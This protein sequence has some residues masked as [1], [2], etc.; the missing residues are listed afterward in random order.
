MNRRLAYVMSV[1]VV[2]LG[3]K[4]TGYAQT[5]D[6][7]LQLASREPAFYAIIGSHL[8]RAEARNVAALREHIGLHL[9][10]VTIPEALKV[11][12]TQT[13]LRFVFK[14]SILPPG[15]TVSLDANDITVAAALTQVLLDADVDVEIAPYGLTSIVARQPRNTAPDT[16]TGG[17]VG[18][19][20]DAK[21]HAGISY[22]TV[23]LDGAGHTATANDSGSFRLARI[24][25]GTYTIVARRVGYTVSRQSVTVVGGQVTTVDFALEQSAGQLN[26]VVVTGSLVPTETK[27]LPTPITVVN[28]SEIAQQQPR[29]LNDIFR[30]AVPTAVSFD[31]FQ[32]P[33]ATYLSVRGATDLSQ[34]GTQIKTIIDGVEVASNSSSPIDPASIDHIEVIRGPEAAAIYGSGAIDG[35]IQIFTKHGGATQGRPSVDAQVGVADVQTPYAGFRGVLRQAYAADVRGGTDDASYTVGGG[36]TITNNYLP[37]GAYSAQSTPSVYGGIH[38]GRGIT[39]LDVSARYQIVNAPSTSNPQFAATEPP[40]NPYRVP[41]FLADAYD[42]ATIGATMS[43]QPLPQWRNGFTIGYDENNWNEEQRRPRFTTASDTELSYSYSNTNKIS[44]RYTSSLTQ[45]FGSAFSGTLI[46][47]ADYWAWDNVATGSYGVLNTIGSIVTD[48]ASP[49]Y[50][51]RYLSHNTGVFSQAQIAIFDALFLTAGVRADWNSDFGDSLGVPL[52]PR[53]GIAYS[54]PLGFSTLKFRASWGNAIVPPIPGEKDLLIT[55]YGTQLA[56]PTLGPERQHGGDG[57]FDLL[58]GNVGSFSA[59]YFNQTAYNLIQQVNIPNRSIYTIQAQ[60]V[61]TVVNSGIELEGRVGFGPFSLRAMYGYTRARLETLASTYSGDLQ[62]GDQMLDVPRSNAGATLSVHLWRGMSVAAGL[63]YV[64]SWT[65]YNYIQMNACNNG[66]ASACNPSYTAT[67][68]TR[69]F[70]M[71]Y[72]ALVKGNLSVTQPLNSLVSAFIAIDNIG[73]DQ[74]YEGSN[75]GPQVGRIS[76]V[77]LRLHY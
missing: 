40:S 71:P 50:T 44:M 55:P 47:G 64:G 49:F 72:P 35:V 16:T 5:L 14:P 2:V 57:G 32:S 18:R 75:N 39:T 20:T 13:S 69:G 61:G 63:T 11:V 17:V 41:A 62:V 9:H 10:N 28:D 30:Q 60:T 33:N 23:S 56:N 66:V 25:G 29:T 54:Q 15:A 65:D 53:V 1:G 42:N 8:E 48:P 24:R 58:F 45:R 12:E 19:V 70:L 74:G 6:K 37:L 3:T 76:T 43:V 26:Q 22:A 77:G 67:G 36:Y 4:T 73:D 46:V 52:S 7:P 31:G 21:T 51:S 68:S 27:S 59:T 38:Y 34:G